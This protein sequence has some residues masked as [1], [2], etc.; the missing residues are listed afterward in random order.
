MIKKQI[1]FMILAATFLSSSAAFAGA[2]TKAL[3]T[4]N[5]T[6]VV[7][8]APKAPENKI[9]DRVEASLPAAQSEAIRILLLASI[10]AQKDYF[11]GVIEV[12]EHVREKYELFRSAFTGGALITG[13]VGGGFGYVT[14]QSIKHTEFTKDSLNRL[15]QMLKPAAESSRRGWNLF[16]NNKIVN[17]VG[18]SVGK[19]SERSYESIRPM[20]KLVFRKGTAYSVG[21]SVLGGSLAMSVYLARHNARE[22]MRSEMARSLL[23]YDREFDRKLDSLIERTALVY[24]V[25]PFQKA[26][27]KNGLR[28]ELMDLAIRNDFRT[29]DDKGNPYEYKV[30]VV[31]I[32]LEQNIIDPE[33]A[34]VAER[35][36][37][38][39]EQAWGTNAIR[40]TTEALDGSIATVLEIS[41]LLESIVESEQLPEAIEKEVRQKLANTKKTIVRLQNNLT[42]Q[43]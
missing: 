16:W 22:A 7:P 17:A 40:T 32:M 2:E 3:A 35:L 43:K 42:N 6:N 29:E 19:S 41:A 14:Y 33:V 23:G 25:E 1:N 21:S 9:V 11:P 4:K 27:L 18:K 10:L 38:L 5:P 13:S 15:W 24:T 31:K 8:A 37:K 30:D 39:A 12:P 26:L 36:S 20:L 34:E 28:R